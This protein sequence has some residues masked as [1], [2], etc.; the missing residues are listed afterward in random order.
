MNTNFGGSGSNAL[1]Y[2]LQVLDELPQQ[3]VTMNTVPKFSF[4]RK[5]ASYKLFLFFL[6]LPGSFFRISKWPI[7]EFFI[8]ITPI[9]VLRLLIYKMRFRPQSYVFSHHS[10]FYL[11]A[12]VPRQSRIFL[13]QDLMYFRAK[14][15][16]WPLG[17][18]KFILRLELQVYKFS[19]KVLVLSYQEKRILSRFLSQPVQL[20]SC[21]AINRKL[22]TE[23]QSNNIV[24]VSDWRRPE[25]VE[26]L[27]SFVLLAT[28][29]APPA[30]KLNL[31]V[32]GFGSKVALD[33][34]RD[35][36]ITRLFAINHGGEYE[37]L[38]DIQGGSYLVPIY[39][40]AGIKLKTLESI[41]QNRFVFGTKNAFLGLPTFLIDDIGIQV[42]SPN[43]ILTLFARQRKANF[44]NFKHEYESRYLK[45]SDAVR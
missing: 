3:I 13:I 9:N 2:W 6:F 12:L 38:S 23:S 32:Y 40:G 36:N 22:E 18:Q 31:I 4:K 44:A 20:V 39:E 27:R 33:I 14:H 7:F 11:M 10:T 34:L 42:D 1:R 43:D 35:P 19:N 41:S 28:E 15:S 30:I 37:S 26:G 24:V 5:S 17:M 16:G 45:L 25:N 8:K 29:Q 21:M